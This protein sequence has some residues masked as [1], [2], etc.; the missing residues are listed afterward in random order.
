[1]TR[2]RWHSP[3]ARALCLATGHADPAAGITRLAMDLIDEVGF[4]GPPVSLPVLASFQGIR[5]IR[6]AAMASA[7]RLIPSGDALL[8]EVN[9]DHSPERQRFSIAHEIVH[10][11]IPTYD[12]RPIEDAQTG[13]FAS[14]SEE[15]L[16][17]DIGAS[18][19]LLDARWLCPLALGADPKIQA[20]LDLA[21]RFEASL[22]ATAWKLATLDLWPI[23]FVFWELGYRKNERTA[24]G[25]V[26]LPEL[27]AFG[28]PVPKLRVKWSAAAESFGH[29]V[30]PNKS[31]DTTSRVVTCWRTEK[32]TR[33]IETFVWRRSTIN[34]YCESVYAPYRLGTQLIPRV[35]SLLLAQERQSEDVPSHRTPGVPIPI[36]VLT[37]KDG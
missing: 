37:E 27:R 28:G 17:C 36:P 30:P 5:E 19:L 34:A 2:R 14:G 16:L 10:T 35:V 20:L 12:R 8:I 29:F 21:T 13:T 32:P 6:T 7:A 26:M 9:Q 24:P 1:M 3:V 15:E 11:L 18:A 4:D 22:Q 31:A 25:Q 33:G 23:A